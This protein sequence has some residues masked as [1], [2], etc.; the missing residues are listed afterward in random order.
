MNA[1]QSR[2]RREPLKEMASST[3]DS[4]AANSIQTESESVQSEVV[5]QQNETEA[6]A[7]SGEKKW[8]VINPDAAGEKRITSPDGVKQV[9]VE[10]DSDGISEP[11]TKGVYDHFLKVESYKPYEG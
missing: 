9:V 2:K 7:L 1:R 6:D 5:E 4:I 11:L 10:F 8:R 3:M